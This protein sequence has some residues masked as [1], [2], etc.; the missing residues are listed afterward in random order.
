[1]NIVPLKRLPLH[2]YNQISQ[3]GYNS[4][5]LGGGCLHYFPYLCDPIGCDCDQRQTGSLLCRR[6][7]MVKSLISEPAL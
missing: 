2:A 6:E 5:L 4:V 7:K 1:M 3:L